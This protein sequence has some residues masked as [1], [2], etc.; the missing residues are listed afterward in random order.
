MILASVSL[1]LQIYHANMDAH[2]IIMYLKELFGATRCNE[3]SETSK[4]LFCY[5]MTEGSSVNT[6]VVRMIG[7][8]KE[9]RPIE[10]LSWSMS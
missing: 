5:K 7:Y 10:L 2:I 3:R 8:F 4:E 1:E 6:Y 9:I